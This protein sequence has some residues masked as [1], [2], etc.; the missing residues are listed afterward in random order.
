LESIT[1]T[2]RLHLL[3][4]HAE[5]R[6]P[7]ARDFLFD[8]QV[9]HARQTNSVARAFVVANVLGVEM[10]ALFSASPALPRA[11]LS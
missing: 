10:T 3:E 1:G 7:L 8:T 5:E 9:G 6:L 11:R 2:G 4:S